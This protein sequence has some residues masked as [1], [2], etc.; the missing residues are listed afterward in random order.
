MVLPMIVCLIPSQ[1]LSA[2]TIKSLFMMWLTANSHR[3]IKVAVSLCAAALI[4]FLIVTIPPGTIP[5]PPNSEFSDAAI[6]HWPSAQFLRSSIL[7]HQT[8][9]FWNPL[10][11]LGQP[12]AANPLNKVWYPPQWLVLILPPT[13]HL[14]VLIYLHGAWLVFGMLVWARRANLH[15]FAAIS[16]TLMWGFAP[17]LIAHLGA[18]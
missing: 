3:P 7:E 10:R 11:M 5:Y 16:A 17:K 13:L 18:G 2:L 1:F 6:S 4:V 8:F 14:D 9:P 15:L 12:F